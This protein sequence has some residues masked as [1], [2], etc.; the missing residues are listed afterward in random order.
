MGCER[1]KIN[2]LFFGDYWDNMWR[3]KQQLAWR[4]ARGDRIHRVIYIERP[5]TLT[6]AL[7]YILGKGDTDAHLRWPRVLRNRSL[8]M[9]R[10]RDFYVFTPVV[11]WPLLNANALDRISSHIRY[12][13][14]FRYLRRLIREFS[15]H[16]PLLWI[17]GHPLPSVFVESVGPKFVWYDCTEDFALS[18]N[19]PKWQR[20]RITQ[21]DRYL[22][23]RADVLSVVSH[24]LYAHKRSVNPNTYLIPNAVDMDVFLTASFDQP[25]QEIQRIPKPRLMFIGMVNERH[26]WN[27]IRYLTRSHPEWS[28]VL[29]GPIDLSRAMRNSL[30]L[31]VHFLGKKPYQELS[32]YLLHCDVCIQF[33]LQDAMNRTRNAQKIFLYLASG[34]PIVSTRS[35]DVAAYA[36]VI[37]IVQ[38]REE[39]KEAV[40][41]ALIRDAPELSAKR[42]ALAEANSWNRRIKKIFRIL[43]ERFSPVG[44]LS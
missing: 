14:M 2:I 33:Y 23:Q 3:R 40:E 11:P 43:N 28:V 38:T 39:F 22:T 17:S 4:L 13:L 36:N 16:D 24:E 1:G 19:I 26:D 34:K 37:S 20:E 15:M 18:P 42:R 9:H 5:L 27:L 6:S 41:N 7:K 29:I 21:N 25:P 31:S 32:S 12:G 8:L 30:G 10:S 35:A 44:G